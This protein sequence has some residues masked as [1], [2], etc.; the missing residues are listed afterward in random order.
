MEA[1]SRVVRHGWLKKLVQGRSLKLNPVGWGG[2]GNLESECT[3]KDFMERVLVGKSRL[4]LQ[5]SE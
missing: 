1:D 4:E 2:F 5:C 3:W